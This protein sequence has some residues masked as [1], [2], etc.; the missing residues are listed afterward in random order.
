MMTTLNELFSFLQEMDDNDATMG[1]VALFESVYMGFTISENHALYLDRATRISKFGIISKVASFGNGM[2]HLVNFGESQKTYFIVGNLLSQG[3]IESGFNLEELVST[4][5]DTSPEYDFS[6]D[7]QLF[8]TGL[9]ADFHSDDHISPFI[10]N[11][12]TVIVSCL[13]NHQLL[14]TILSKICSAMF[15][16]RAFLLEY[17][18]NTMFSFEGVLNDEK[19]EAI[20]IRFIGY[21]NENV[22]PK[23]TF[24][25]QK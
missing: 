17:F 8:A 14:K 13:S 15:N 11:W 19:F 2:F 22:I 3:S 21:V 25:D 16:D 23:L 18:E 6:P 5:I 20:F 7:G 4:Y 9:F 12:N 1:M 10:V 24:E